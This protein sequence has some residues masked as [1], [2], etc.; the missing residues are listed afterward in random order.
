MNDEGRMKKAHALFT[1]ALAKLVDPAGSAVGDVHRDL[2]AETQ[3]GE[4]RGGPLHGR[5]PE[6]LA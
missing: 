5:S 6:G 4:G 2:E 1:R 3:V